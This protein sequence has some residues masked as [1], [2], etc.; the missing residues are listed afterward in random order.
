MIHM[1]NV[2]RT[3]YAMGT[4]SGKALTQVNVWI[5]EV[6]QGDRFGY[7]R[8]SKRESDIRKVGMEDTDYKDFWLLL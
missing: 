4:A 7:I 5:F 3:F 6:L 1:I 2:G 8:I